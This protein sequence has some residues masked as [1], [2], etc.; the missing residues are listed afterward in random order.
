MAAR[1]DPFTGT[2]GLGILQRMLRANVATA[3]TLFFMMMVVSSHAQDG[4]TKHG[5]T[6]NEYVVTD[7]NVTFAGDTAPLATTA[8]TGDLIIQR[9]D[10][11]SEVKIYTGGFAFTTDGLV[12]NTQVV[13]PKGGAMFVKV[14]LDL[15]SDKEPLAPE[16]AFD[17]PQD[18]QKQKGQPL[19]S[20]V[21]WKDDIALSGADGSPMELVTL[22]G[23][24]RVSGG[25]IPLVGFNGLRIWKGGNRIAVIFAGKDTDPTKARLRIRGK[26]YG[27]LASLRK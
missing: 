9:I 6:P 2:P 11:L 21:L 3:L 19:W 4:V 13:R 14:I 18:A 1:C 26:D 15:Y 25:A 17:S 12:P 10:K 7:D 27:P 23:Q 16:A 5:K 8:T 20:E 22:I 24:V